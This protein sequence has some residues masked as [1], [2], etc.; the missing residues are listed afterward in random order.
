MFVT[1]AKLNLPGMLIAPHSRPALIECDLHWGEAG[2]IDIAS[3]QGSF[4]EDTSVTNNSN[5]QVMF[6]C[7][8]IKQKTND[9]NKLQ[10]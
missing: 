1:I 10:Q 5:C 6:D 8:N 4:L 3:M 9:D 2:A 7:H